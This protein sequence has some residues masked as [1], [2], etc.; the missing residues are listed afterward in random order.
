MDM[1]NDSAAENICRD[2][3]REILARDDPEKGLVEIF[4]FLY[5]KDDGRC[6]DLL[7]LLDAFQVISNASFDELRRRLTTADNTIHNLLDV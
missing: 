6:A 2:K 3:A 7:D 4:M 5:A 1:E